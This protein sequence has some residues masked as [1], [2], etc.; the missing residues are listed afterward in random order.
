MAQY[1]RNKYEFHIA[2]S[3]AGEDRNLA[4]QVADYLS[5]FGLRVFYDDWEKHKLVGEDLYTYLADIYQ[6]KSKYCAIFISKHYVKKAW[7]KHERKFAQARAFR[8]KTAY[9]LPIKVDDS[10]CPG[11]PPIVGYIDSRKLTPS[12]IAILLLKKIGV[13]LYKGN[14]DELVLSRYMRW[15]I[16]WDGSI[17]AHGKFSILYVGRGEKE[18]LTLNVWSPDERPLMM[19]NLRAFDSKG[20]LRTKII[21]K[22]DT[23]CEFAVYPRKPLSFGEVLDYDVSYRCVKYY[24]NVTALCRDE[25]TA[26]L[27]I[28]LWE[29]EFVFPVHS[30]LKI[31]RIYRRVNDHE[32]R[33]SYSTTIKDGHPT[34]L[35]SL[36]SPKVGSI[37]KIEFKLERSK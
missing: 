34:V 10:E 17:D 22:T 3:F 31:F 32:Y 28:K 15:K 20:D 11:I 21:G 2:L 9:I 35:Y 25:F 36:K 26:S 29:Y 12:Q 19:M 8:E 4:K 24:N 14:A 6:K 18:K 7:P 5:F 1:H 27:P 30:I 33:Q 23:S 16:D 13:A 37:L